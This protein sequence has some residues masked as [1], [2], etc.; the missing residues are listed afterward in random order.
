MLKANCSPFKLRFINPARTSRGVM[1]EKHGFLLRVHDTAAPGIQGVGECTV[2]AGLSYDDKPEYEEVLRSL[3]A[4]INKPLDILLRE[5]REWPSLLFGL[6][7]ALLDLSN[8]GNGILFNT[9]FTRGEESIAINGLVWMGD[10][11]YMLSQI[12]QKISEGY[13][14]IKLKIGALDFGKEL[15][16]IKYIRQHHSPDEITIR[17]DANG[18]FDDSLF[19]KLHHL[20]K[21]NI[22]SI[23][24]PIMPGNHGLMAEIC[25]QS[26]I[27]VA[28][29]EELIGHHDQEDMDNLLS[30]IRPQYII[31]KPSLVGGF[32][33]CNQWISLSNKYGTGYWITSALESNIGL[34]AIAQYTSSIETHGLP[35]GLGTGGLFVENFEVPLNMTA[36]RLY[37]SRFS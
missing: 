37:Y 10:H 20:S 21:Y 35:Q 24:Q 6:E 17:L 1:T 4:D 30:T 27:P 18:A 32:T 11:D 13:K 31:L 16:L 23:E 2:L 19:D 3:C 28:L 29:D 25:R 26:P 5:Y 9:P 14:V 36:G 7:S 8:G 12:K 34:N 15:G 22:H 33:A